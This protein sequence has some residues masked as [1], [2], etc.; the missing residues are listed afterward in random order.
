MNVKAPYWKYQWSAPYTASRGQ[1]RLTI[2]MTW[3]TTAA[4]LTG[5]PQR[6]SEKYGPWS[7]R[8]QSPRM[9]A[10]SIGSVTHV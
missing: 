6:P 9:R 5:R 3:Y 8:G 10:S 2:A 1:A 4:T 7:A